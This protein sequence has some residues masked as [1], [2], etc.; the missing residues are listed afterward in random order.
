MAEDALGVVAYSSE[1]WIGMKDPG[2]PRARPKVAYRAVRVANRMVRGLVV[3]LV[4]GEY[5]CPSV[6][7]AAVRAEL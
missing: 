5:L 7:Y 6:A 4:L 3:G 2:F 1:S